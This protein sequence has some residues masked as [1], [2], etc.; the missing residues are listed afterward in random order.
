MKLRSAFWF[1]RFTLVQ[2]LLILS[3]TVLLPQVFLGA[4]IAGRYTSQH[5]LGLERAAIDAARDRSA[6]LDRELEGMIGALQA[7]ATSPL[8]DTNSFGRFRAEAL[9]LL[10][11]RGTAIVMR[12]RAGRHIINTLQ[13]A[14]AP[15]LVSTDPDLLAND[16]VIF[17]TKAPAV[18][19]LYIGAVTK[20]LFVN[21][22]VPVIRD[23]E[24]R[25]VLAIAV[26]PETLRNSLL[27][28]TP[29]G[30]I[31]VI[32]DRKMQVI[33]RSTEQ[34]LFVGKL[35][36]RPMQELLVGESGSFHGGFSLEGLPI[37]SAYQKSLLAGWTVA[38][39][40]PEDMLHAPLRDL[41]RTLLLMGLSAIALSL[42]GAFLY[43]RILRRGLNMLARL[44]RRVGRDD[45]S[46]GGPTD[47]RE[48]DEVIKL[49]ATADADLKLK[50]AHQ[51]TLLHELDHRVKNTLAIIQSLVTQSVRG[52]TSPEHFREA[53]IG[54]VMAL[55]RSH[56]VLSAANWKDPELG[57]V[58]GAVLA[59]EAERIHCEGDRVSLAPRVVVAFAQVFHE[60]LANAEKH[61][62][63]SRAEGRVTLTWRLEGGGLHILWI[64][65]SSEPP[66][67]AALKGLGTTIVRICI[68]R[69]LG[70]TCH[71][72]AAPQGLRLEAIVPLVSDLG[73]NGAAMDPAL[74][75]E[76]K[77]APLSDGATIWGGEAP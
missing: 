36:A 42:L 15:A 28:N 46:P 38:F 24:V 9:Q 56:E 26:A 45:F 40:I 12:D 53:I 61:G 35:T 52:S 43:G 33:A 18:S 6:G 30:W 41:W 27:S 57:S 68:E 64:E 74:A 75:T 65:T 11:F 34:E 8:I 44:A 54:R 73:V 16:A 48:M 70:G 21:V 13:P 10:S 62:A 49:L 59:R 4:L 3:L 1:P 31:G 71:F 5:K 51:R 23:N 63:L 55:A 29:E 60:L 2:H 22:G 77:G 76:R 19:N 39:A 14:D 7:L 25:Y 37:F 17:A 72:E 47:V 20:M 66:A 32:L 50:D 58:A 67:V 69:Q